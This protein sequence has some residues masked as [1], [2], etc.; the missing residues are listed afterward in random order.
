MSSEIC[1]ATRHEGCPAG[2]VAGSK[3]LP[4]VAME[5]FMVEQ[6]ITPVWIGGKVP[7]F[8]MAGA[9]TMLSR[10]K[11]AYE[12]QGEFVRDGAEVHELARTS[13]TFDL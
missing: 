12:T 5:V 7:L 8:A 9:T 10:E 4:G 1:Q 13:G 11:K 6:E 2:L 3:P